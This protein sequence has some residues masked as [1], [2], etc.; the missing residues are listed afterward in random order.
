MKK[1]ALITGAA[2]RIGAHL[3]K[4]LSQQGF[5][6]AIHYHTS[7]TKA[8]ELKQTIEQ[9]GGICECFQA[10]LSDSTDVQQL[11]PQVANHFPQL[12]LLVNNASL[13]EPGTFLET[14]MASYE[15][16]FDVNLKAPFLLTQH[17]A[18]LQ[19]TKSTAK[20]VINLLDTR[21]TKNPKTYFAYTLSKKA[22]HA[23][24]Q[25]AAK[26]LA[27][28]VRVNAIALGATLPPEGKDDTYLQDLIQKTPLQQAG[29]LGDLSSL[30]LT[31]IQNPL[32][33]GQ[34]LFF[35]GGAHL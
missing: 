6:I 33:T 34:T 14:D 2:K 1:T 7:K 15:R 27:P 8:F 13:F 10:N 21:I 12:S 5:S 22:L 31:L 9:D 18:L 4:R 11:I 16:Q 20:N 26:T 30:L 32:I 23:F 28:K 17:F 25:A 3:A 29:K 24:T 19:V 35:D